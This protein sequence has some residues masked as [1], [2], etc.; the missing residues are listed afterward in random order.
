MTGR[1]SRAIRLTWVNVG[2]QALVN[3]PR[4]GDE[5]PSPS[6][7][8]LAFIWLSVSQLSKARSAP[9]TAR[10]RPNVLEQNHPAGRC[11]V[12]LLDGPYDGQ[13]ILAA[14]AEL[15]QGVIVRGSHMY[16]RFGLT[17][18]QGSV[19]ATMPLFRWWEEVRE[20]PR[21]SRR[22][23]GWSQAASTRPVCFPW[24][25]SLT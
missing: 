25:N 16:V 12:M 22:L 20:P 4:H 13:D 3:M 6:A 8:V 15:T 21:E 10:L 9:V 24:R 14:N 18:M 11:V 17:S 19:S 2:L 23:L 5:I 1:R 7:Y